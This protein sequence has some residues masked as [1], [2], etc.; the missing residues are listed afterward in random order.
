MLHIFAIDLDPFQVIQDFHQ[1]VV[2]FVR[3]QIF[4]VADLV[5]PSLEHGLL[6]CNLNLLQVVSLTL[7]TG[8]R[9]VPLLQQKSLYA[10]SLPLLR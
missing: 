4:Q 7:Q 10:A 5:Q 3:L 9:L 8:L 6:F 1:Y 2:V